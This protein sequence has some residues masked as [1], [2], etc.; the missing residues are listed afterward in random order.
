MS[1]SIE[2]MFNIEEDD[3]WKHDIRNETLQFSEEQWSVVLHAPQ[4]GEGA[5]IASCA[6]FL[7][8]LCAIVTMTIK[9]DTAVIR[10]LNKFISGHVCHIL[11]GL[12]IALIEDFVRI[13]HPYYFQHQGVSVFSDIHSIKFQT[14]RYFNPTPH[15]SEDRHHFVDIFKFSSSFLSDVRAPILFFSCYSLYN[16]HFARQIIYIF[17]YGF[18]GRFLFLAITGFLIKWLA[19]QFV[20]LEYFNYGCAWSF[21]GISAIVDPLSGFSVFKDT[22][23]K[24]FFLLLGIYVVGNTIG[25]EIF[26]AALQLA[27][28]PSNQA[29]P[30]TTVMVLL[31]S[32]ILNI[33]ISLLIG[34]AVGLLTSFFSRFIH[35]TKSCE[36]YEPFITLGGPLLTMLFCEWNG[37]SEI[38]GVIICCLIQERYVFLNLSTKSV[39]S[40]K[41]AME[42]FAFLSN[43]LGFVVIG[44]KLF[45][46]FAVFFDIWKFVLMVL[47]VS[48]LVRLVIILTITCVLNFKRKR[49][50]GTRLQGLLLFGG[51]RGPRSYALTCFYG[52]APYAALFRDAQLLLILFSVIVDTLISKMLVRSIKRKLDK[53]KG[54]KFVPIIPL[55]VIVEDNLDGCMMRVIK[56][57]ERILGCLVPD[58]DREHLDVWDERE[59]RDRKMEEATSEINHLEKDPA[60]ASKKN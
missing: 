19:S 2:R 4:L 9:E 32:I 25:V 59:D 33:I 38:F 36:F 5:T 47:L 53:I 27:P 44:Y 23:Q 57:E 30:A 24:N 45:R 28:Y 49:P 1:K 16:R 39:M 29:I 35:H 31:L 58:E 41:V 40:I 14:G 48:Y 37:R 56:L 55:P 15:N 22:S 21:A 51:V 60:K 34:A 12:I 17:L 18:C 13:H 7:S 26:K 50:I 6:V 20:G 11:I 10:A 54:D 43:L 8:I 52:N 46:S 3:S 42:A